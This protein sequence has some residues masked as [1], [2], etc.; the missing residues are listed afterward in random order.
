MV[1]T[2]NHLRRAF[3]NLKSVALVA[4]PESLPRDPQ[5]LAKYK[6]VAVVMYHCNVSKKICISNRVGSP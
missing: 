1:L 5:N 4:V 6:E 3:F 2:N